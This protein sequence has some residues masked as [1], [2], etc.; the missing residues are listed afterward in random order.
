MADFEVLIEEL[1]EMLDAPLYPDINSVVVVLVE[2]KVKVQ[3]EPDKRGDFF[4]IGAYIGELP[5]GKFREHILKD[6]LKVNFNACKNL[7]ILSYT[8]KHN[9]LMIHRKIHLE[10][11]TVDKLIEA[12]KHMT[13]RAKKWQEAMDSGHTSPEDEIPKIGAQKDPGKMFGM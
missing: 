11:L 1:A 5:P 8:A 4:L 10:A 13:C 12:I 3:L 7:G 9:T 6:A 2:G